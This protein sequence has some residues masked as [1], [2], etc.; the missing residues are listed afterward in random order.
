MQFEDVQ[1]VKEEFGAEAASKAIKEGWKLLGFVQSD[2]YDAVVYVL[3]RRAVPE[4]Q[5]GEYVQG[6]WVPKE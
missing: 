2:K 5:E 1:E 6:R 3:G 4:A